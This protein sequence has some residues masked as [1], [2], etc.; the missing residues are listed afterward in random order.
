[1]QSRGQTSEPRAR[2]FAP[3]AHCV[4]AEHCPVLM[5]RR[6]MAGSPTPAPVPESFRRLCV[7]R[8]EGER[9]PRLAF[10]KQGLMIIRKAGPDGVAHAVAVIGPGHLLGQ[11]ASFAM[12]S[13][14]TV[15]AATPVAVCHFPARLLHEMAPPSAGTPGVALRHRRMVVQ[16][17]AD[18]SCL[19]RLPGLMQRFETALRLLAALQPTRP[20]LVPGQGVMAEL[21]GVTRES[22]NRAWREAEARGIVRHRHG[23][24][25]DLDLLRLSGPHRAPT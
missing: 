8:R 13:V 5:H 11:S 23:Q 4:V 14:F 17:L 22:I 12:P 7:L 24:T 9:P 1:M 16:T 6:Q 21:L 25:V 2:G 15:Q 20:L 3:C 10:V 18:W 19:A